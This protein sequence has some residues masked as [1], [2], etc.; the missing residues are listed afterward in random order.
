MIKAAVMRALLAAPTSAGA[1]AL[2]PGWR[3]ATVE[4]ILTSP[5]LIQNGLDL[6]SALSKDFY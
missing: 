1:D 5:A 3:K 4:I 2:L 6:P